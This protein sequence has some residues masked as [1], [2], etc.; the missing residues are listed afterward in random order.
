MVR[1]HKVN[2]SN[3]IFVPKFFQE[4]IITN[5]RLPLSILEST[6]GSIWITSIVQNTE[7]P[8]A[9]KETSLK[10]KTPSLKHKTHL[11]M[12]SYL[13]NFYIF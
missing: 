13:V 8:I 12:N 11:I 3:V 7:S 9:C 1:I 6:R 5:V 10:H 2:I 4:S